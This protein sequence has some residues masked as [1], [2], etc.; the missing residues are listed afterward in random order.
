M[1]VHKGVKVS[2]C[3]DLVSGDEGL[4]DDDEER[5]RRDG[6]RELD[7]LLDFLFLDISLDGE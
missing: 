3:I 4:G 2:T 6:L 7:R 5:R 1:F